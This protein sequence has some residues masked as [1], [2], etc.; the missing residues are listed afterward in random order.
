MFA[1]TPEW[2]D[3]TIIGRNKTQAHATYIPFPDE[4]RALTRD[5]SQSPW[6]KSLNGSWKF[7]FLEKPADVLPAYSQKDFNDASWDKIP[8][9][10]NWQVKGYGQPV[11]TGSWVPPSAEL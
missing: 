2:Q 1:Q 7:K 9:P 6:V 5:A 3:E 11:D 4:V 10:S 8:V